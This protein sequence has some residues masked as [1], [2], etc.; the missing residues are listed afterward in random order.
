M[1]SRGEEPA[2]RGGYLD[3]CFIRGRRPQ[4]GI[5]MSTMTISQALRRVKKLKGE[6]ASH[7]S[8]AHVAVTHRAEQTPAFVFGAGQV[9]RP[10]RSRRDRQSQDGHLVHRG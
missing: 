5:E 9:R 10:E 7:L 4:K 1:D 8:R 3:R 6:L 2:R